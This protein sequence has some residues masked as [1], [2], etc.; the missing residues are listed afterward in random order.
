MAYL[1]LEYIL[2]AK[3]TLDEKLF[4]EYYSALGEDFKYHV[5]RSIDGKGWVAVFPLVISYN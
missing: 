3:V 4:Q 2:Q 1:A 5:T